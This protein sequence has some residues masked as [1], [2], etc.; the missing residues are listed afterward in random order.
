MET[1]SAMHSAEATAKQV[2]LSLSWVQRGDVALG[3]VCGRPKPARS[4]ESH[5]ATHHFAN[6]LKIVPF[7][8]E[9][10]T[11]TCHIWPSVE[12]PLESNNNLMLSTETAN[13]SVICK[14]RSSIGEIVA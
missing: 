5:C 8:T 6:A 12:I 1:N 11:L 4:L 3:T 10:Q 13:C 14:E 7:G 9:D 2:L